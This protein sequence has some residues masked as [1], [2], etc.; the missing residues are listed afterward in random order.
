MCV[1]GPASTFP[2]SSCRLRRCGHAVCE[3]ALRRVPSGGRDPGG[4]AGPHSGRAAALALCQQRRAVAQAHVRRSPPPASP[5]CPSS[6]ESRVTRPPRKPAGRRCGAG[7]GA[8]LRR[9]ST[10][11]SLV[12]NDI[13]D[14]RQ[15]AVVYC[16]HKA[17]ADELTFQFRQ[18]GYPALVI[19]EE[20][21]APPPRDGTLIGFAKQRTWL[22]PARGGTA[23]PFLGRMWSSGG[24]C[25][26]SSRWATPLC[27]S[28]T[29]SPCSS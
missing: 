9:P 26:M 25:S 2:A 7:G 1:A 24:G 5:L 4:D 18:H 27:W 6:R 11:V 22:P 23:L 15:K 20:Q 16:A 29:T 21:V 12:L 3:G 14:R 13:L 19:P 10:R 28:Q 17:Q 8:E